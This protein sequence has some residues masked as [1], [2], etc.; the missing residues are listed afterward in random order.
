VSSPGSYLAIDPSRK[1]GWAS[2]DRGGGNLRYGTW[3]FKQERAGECY[4]IYLSNLR[5]KILQG[6]DIQIG[7]EML[8]AVAH[9]DDK[10]KASVDVQQIAFSSGWQTHAQT[11]CFRMGAR[12]PEIVAISAWRSKTHGKVSAPKGYN[13]DSRKYLKQAALDYC[14][15]HGLSPANDEEAEAICILHYLRLLHEPDFAFERGR[16]HHQEALL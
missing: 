15:A 2:C 8:T 13:G 16:S 5:E 14:A 12:D 7:I 4:A 1:M 9:V 6:D 11:L 3:K 10:G